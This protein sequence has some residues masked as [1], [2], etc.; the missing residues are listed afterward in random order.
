ML[1]AGTHWQIHTA[2]RSLGVSGA[3]TRTRA[4]KTQLYVAS[5]VGSVVSL[6]GAAKKLGVERRRIYDIGT[7]THTFTRAHPFT[8]AILVHTHTFGRAR[9]HALSRAHVRVLIRIAPTTGSS[10]HPRVPRLRESAEEK[11]IPVARQREPTR[12]GD[13]VPKPCLCVCVCVCACVHACVCVCICVCARVRA[14][15]PVSDSIP[16]HNV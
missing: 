6:D 2:L 1:W 9:T 13:L 4:R 5:E 8:R 15:S 7:H 12:Y 16:T 11:Y 3:H 14:S 10:Q